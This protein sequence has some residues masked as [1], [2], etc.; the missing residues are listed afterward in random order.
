MSG[1]GTIVNVAA[2]LGGCVIGL[3]VKGG[4]PKHLEDTITSAVGL[5]VIFV[6]IS[7]ALKGMMTVTAGGLDTRATLVMVLCMVIG[8]ALSEWI[9]IEDRLEQ[10]GIWCKSKIPAGKA[11]GTFVEAFVS[12][13][14][15]FCVGAMAI[16]GALEDGLTHNYSTLFTKAVMD[17]VLSIIFT[18]ALGIG[19][20]FSIFPVAIYQGSITLLAGVVRP[21]LT[22]LMIGRI[23]FIGSILI[24]AL[25]LNLVLNSKLK[26]GNMLPAVFLPVIVCLLGY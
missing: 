3:L 21:Y 16:V 24:F 1:L 11:S 15:L 23:S 4:L 17:G 7:G 25:G 9:D 14:L 2:I 13:S 18:A 19:T 22:E 6:G 12:S 5:C 8:S 10:L 20:A 26:I